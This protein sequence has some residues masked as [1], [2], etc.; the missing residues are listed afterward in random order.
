M[1][2]QGSGAEVDMEKA[3]YWW[4]ISESN[5]IS[6]ARVKKALKRIPKE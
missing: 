4:E 6:P 3:R 2:F 5:G 1:Y